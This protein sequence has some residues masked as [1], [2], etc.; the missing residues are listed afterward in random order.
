M[1][2]PPGLGGS[3]GG[4]GGF[5]HVG[6]VGAFCSTKARILQRA[7]EVRD[8]VEADSVNVEKY[9]KELAALMADL[10]KA[11]GRMCEQESMRMINMATA[12]HLGGVG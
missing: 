10:A 12:L 6:E 5:G 9:F 7:G 2:A 3:T 11:A 1:T 8:N 4:S